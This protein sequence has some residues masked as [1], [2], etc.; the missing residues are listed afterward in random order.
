M[1]QHEQAVCLAAEMG[2]HPDHLRQRYGVGRSARSSHC[3][4]NNATAWHA[5]HLMAVVQLQHMHS[6]QLSSGLHAA[7]Y[8]AKRWRA[9]EAIA[10][11]RSLLEK[12]SGAQSWIA[13]PAALWS[14][15]DNTCLPLQHPA[16][17][18]PVCARLCP[19]LGAWCCAD[20]VCPEQK[21]IHTKCPPCEC[22]LQDKVRPHIRLRSR[23]GTGATAAC[24]IMVPGG[25]PK[26]GN[27][28]CR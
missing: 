13:H 5:A 6:W 25:L 1:Q 14:S 12:Y 24:S 26:T 17:R 22:R 27:V 10:Q 3:A 28:E 11:P 9:P 21:V 18:F 2:G 15:I 23:G 16:C 20:T 8:L 19:E 4:V 7:M